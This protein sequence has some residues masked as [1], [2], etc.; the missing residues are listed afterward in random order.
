MVFD[1]TIV[2]GVKRCL[3]WY[4]ENTVFKYHGLPKNSSIFW[5]FRNSTHQ[6]LSFSSLLSTYTFV[7]V[8]FFQ[9]NQTDL[10]FEQHYGFDVGK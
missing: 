1:D 8:F 7:C 4:K 9:C 2:L 5:S 10:G 3:G 6:D